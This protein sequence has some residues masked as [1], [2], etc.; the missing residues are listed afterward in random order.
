MAAGV[1]VSSASWGDAVEVVVCG[2]W[3]GAVEVVI[4][5]WGAVMVVLMPVLDGGVEAGGVDI[6][7]FFALET[8]LKRFWE[9]FFWMGI[10][11]TLDGPWL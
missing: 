11:S 4:G 5:A 9:G 3:G 6:L 8:D 2:A 7:L 1:F 10:R